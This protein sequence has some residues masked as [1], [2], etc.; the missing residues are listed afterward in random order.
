[1]QYQRLSVQCS[2]DAATKLSSH[3]SVVL[4]GRASPGNLM[5][6]LKRVSVLLVDCRKTPGRRDS[7]NR[8]SLSR[9]GLSS[10]EA[11]R[12]HDTDEAPD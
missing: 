6:G 2:L 1:M 11:N 12:H 4:R 7:P 9:R 5:L 10:G 8:R 3:K